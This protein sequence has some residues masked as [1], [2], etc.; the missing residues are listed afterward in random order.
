MDDQMFSDKVLGCLK[1]YSPASEAAEVE[2]SVQHILNKRVDENK[3]IEVYKAIFNLLDLTTLNT[4]DNAT[5]VQAF[6]NKVNNFKANYADMP[7]VAAICTWPSLIGEVKATLNVPTVGL[8]A[9]SAG[10][11]SSQTFIEIK[12]AETSLAVMSGA[13]E[14]DIVVGTGDIMEDNF[15]KAFEDINECKEACRDAK[16]KV[17]LETGVLATPQN[18]KTAAII[19]MEAGA[20]FIKTSTGK[21]QPAATPELFYVMLLAIKE[22]HQKSGKKIGIKPAGGISSVDD[23][24]VY[25]TLV[26]EVLGKE[27]LN[28]KLF[29]IGASRLANNLLTTIYSKETNYFI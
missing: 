2:K 14:I 7:N 8:C 4:Q 28:N 27:W 15:E 18:V 17:I 6:V 13:T 20:D 9:V 22:F 10:F 25:Y 5:R 12:V 23:A 16:L 1:Q 24:L 21:T 11:P 19:A 26:K 29:R 3:T